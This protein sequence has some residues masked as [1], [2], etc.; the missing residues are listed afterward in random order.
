MDASEL[1]E[2]Y[3]SAGQEYQRELFRLGLKPEATLWAYDVADKKFVYW[4]LW[5]G[6][7]RFGPY[8][9]T[10]LLFSAYRSSRLTREI[11]PF[12][13]HIR[14][15]T[16]FHGSHT[17]GLVRATMEGKSREWVI[18]AN[19]DV[20]FPLYTGRREWVVHCDTKDRPTVQ[21]ISDWKRFQKRIT[22]LAA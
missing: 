15:T 13:V 6:L 10:K 1:P 9:L 3:L 2:G 7:D 19:G 17:L 5:S 16:G 21:M 8:G 12:I 4:L 14:P 22:N 11:N 20:R 18:S